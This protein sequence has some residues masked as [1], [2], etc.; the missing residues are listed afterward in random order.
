MPNVSSRDVKS[1]EAYGMGASISS[2]VDLGS[3][4][5]VSICSGVCAKKSRP[6]MIF[7][8]IEFDGHRTD[9]VK[10]ISTVFDIVMSRDRRW[11]GQAKILTGWENIGSLSLC[12]PPP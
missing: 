4:E 11:V 12:P 5:I 6:K 10:C 3:V 8:F 7:I 9:L 2:P 1:V